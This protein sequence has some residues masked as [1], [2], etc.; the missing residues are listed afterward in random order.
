MMCFSHVFHL[1]AKVAIGCACP[2][3]AGTH[4]AIIVIIQNTLATAQMI[5]SDR[6]H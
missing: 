2:L 5:S 1:T 3:N 6:G 4:R